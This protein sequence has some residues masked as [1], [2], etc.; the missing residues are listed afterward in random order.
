MI[1]GCL[2]ISAKFNVFNQAVV[3]PFSL[4]LKHQSFLLLH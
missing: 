1:W 2:P 3:E 4:N